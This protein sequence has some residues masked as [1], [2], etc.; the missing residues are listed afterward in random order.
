MKI[1]VVTAWFPSDIHPGAGNFVANDAAALSEDHE[2]IVVHLVDPKL[3]D[4]WRDFRLGDVRVLRRPMPWGRPCA[5]AATMR[6]LRRVFDGADIVHTMACPSLI[7]FT[8][9]RS[10]TPVVHTEHWSG[11]LRTPSSRMAGLKIPLLKAL[12]RRPRAVCAVSSY[13]GSALEV[14]TGRAVTVIPNI[15]T[16]PPYSPPR[17]SDGTLRLLSVGNLVAGKHPLLAVDT[18]AELADRGFDVSLWWA[19]QGPLA[20]EVRDHARK[21]QISDRIELLGHVPPALLAARYAEADVVLHTSSDETFCIVAAEALCAGRPLVIQDT[22]GHR[23]FV[24]EPYCTFPTDRTPAAFAHAV[25]QAYSNRRSDGFESYAGGLAEHLGR[26]A[27]RTRWN[28]V[29]GEIL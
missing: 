7:K 18:V 3:D 24:S 8:L 15:V 28:A 6:G 9:S 14:V 29:Y 10:R 17:E 25:E 23:D 13:L 2:V 20:D 1:C 4:G 16:P 5:A 26:Q 22:G 21:L 27:F 12:F 11:I 19:G